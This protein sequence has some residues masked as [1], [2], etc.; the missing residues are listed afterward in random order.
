MEAGPSK[1]LWEGE[2]ETQRHLGIP[3]QVRRNISMVAT[4]GTRD[5]NAYDSAQIFVLSYDA[6]GGGMVLLTIQGGWGGGTQTNG[7]GTYILDKTNR[8]NTI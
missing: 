8:G 2:I 7:G 4:D 6:Y 1:A 5:S 3:F